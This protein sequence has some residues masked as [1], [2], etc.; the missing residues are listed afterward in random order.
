MITNDADTR[1]SYRA[2]NIGGK[3]LRF[4][5]ESVLGEIAAE[6]QYVCAPRNLCKRIVHLPARMLG[7]MKIRSRRD[8]QRSFCHRFK[9]RNG[10]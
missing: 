1:D 7:I 3:F 9:K 6:Q 5:G 10:D 2:A 8:T 4:F